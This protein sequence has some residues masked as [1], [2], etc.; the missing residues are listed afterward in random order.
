MTFTN[1]L[2]QGL[3]PYRQKLNQVL[4]YM[5]EFLKNPVQGMRVLP[6][7]DYQVLL[8]FNASAAAAFGVLAGIVKLNFG[9]IFAGLIVAPIANT[10]VALVGMGFFYYTFLFIFKKEVPPKK[11]LTIVILANLPRL[12]LY[13]IEAYLPQV[14]IV[15]LAATCLLLYVG[16]VENTEIERKNITRL[17]G[18]IFALFLVFWIYN[19][20]SVSREKKSIKDMTTPGTL[21]ILEQD[22]RDQ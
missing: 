22:M 6:N 14:T 10:F 19:T 5:L 8:I 20:I 3:S 1:D 17:I 16:F 13:P 4:R 18:G 21:D 11:V 9:Q 15:S 2:Q 12:A 7:W